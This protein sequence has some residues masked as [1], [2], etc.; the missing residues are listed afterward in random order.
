MK[1][2]IEM[3][4]MK[5]KP[6]SSV[7]LDRILTPSEEGLFMDHLVSRMNEDAVSMT[8]YVIFELMLLTGLRVTEACKLRLKD[9]P[10]YLGAPAIR[11]F[12]GK[13]GKSRDVPI[14]K[15]LAKDIKMYIKQHR[16]ATLP[17][18]FRVSDRTKRLFYS[19]LKKPFNRRTLAYHIGRIG[20]LAGITKHLTPHMCRHTFATM[21]L[22]GNKLKMHELQMFM[23]HAKITTTQLYIHTAMLLT[24]DYGERLDRFETVI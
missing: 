10:R 18:H 15:R 19:P 2:E 11:V 23:G 7:G 24:E 1:K 12:E 22:V 3:A 6:E 20:E 21:A 13:G 9:T 8:F 14:S 4:K 5:R 17:A 16:P